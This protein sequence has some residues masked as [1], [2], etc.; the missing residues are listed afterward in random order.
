MWNLKQ[1]S[2]PTETKH[3]EDIRSTVVVYI[4]CPVFTLVLSEKPPDEIL[5]PRILSFFSDGKRIQ[6]TRGANDLHTS[7]TYNKE[8]RKNNWC[9]RASGIQMYLKKKPFDSYNGL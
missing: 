4:I 8:F 1:K 5:I 3:T 2:F 9:T 6:K 7:T